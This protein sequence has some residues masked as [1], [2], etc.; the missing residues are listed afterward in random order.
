VA[1]VDRAASTTSAR[2]GADASSSL[3]LSDVMLGVAWNVR[4]DPARS[5][6]VAACA[7][8]FALTLPQTPNTS[9]RG[10]GKALLWLGPRSWLFVAAPGNTPND[11]DATREA[12]RA[13]GAALFDV[14]ASYVAWSL[15]G[16]TS[17]AVLNAGCPLDLHPGAFP[18]GAC[19]QSLLGH[20]GALIHRPG[21]AQRFV[22]MV[23]RSYAADAWRD[24]R[25]WAASDGYRIGAAQP[26]PGTN[27][28]PPPS[29]AT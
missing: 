10:D 22:V 21:D 24:L 12:L 5:A 25:A 18:A 27:S 9:T 7:G 26:F 13:V 16:P 14:S 2:A 1:D 23:P 19:A 28:S 6:L 3:V 4:G 15:A 20:V 11:F 8:A 17:A 29:S